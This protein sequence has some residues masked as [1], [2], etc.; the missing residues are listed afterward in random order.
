MRNKNAGFSLVELLVAITI[1]AVVSGSIGYLLITSL[2]M[3]NK[4]TV[5]VALQQELQITLNQIMDYAMESET[6]VSDF[7]GVFPDYLA[8]GTFEDKTLHTQIIWK[9]GNRLFLRKTDIDDFVVIKTD[10]NDPQNKT[11]N[12]E[13]IL[14]YI[15]N[16]EGDSS[17]LYLLA[18]YVKKF[19]SDVIGISEK[20]DGEGN[21][22]EYLFENPI[23]I[24]ITL[25]FE[26]EA[27][28]A[29][30]RVSDKALLRNRVV[31]NIYVKNSVY[32]SGAEFVNSDDYNK[33]STALN[34]TT[35]T[36]NNEQKLGY[37]KIDG[38]EVH[39]VKGDLNI[40]EIIPNYTYDYVQYGIGG[41]NGELLNS[42]NTDYGSDS[43]KPIS[44]AEMEGYMI[45][46]AGSYWERLQDGNFS[47]R[48]VST[49]ISSGEMFLNSGASIPAYQFL[50]SKD[51][52]G[53]YEYVGES[54][55]GVYAI[56][57]YQGNLVPIQNLGQGNAKPNI[58]SFTTTSD[59]SEKYTPKMYSP[60]FELCE[61]DDGSGDY[62]YPEV[63]YSGRND[64]KEVYE[65]IKHNE[66]YTENRFIKYEYVGPGKGDV[67]LLFKKYDYNRPSN[68]SKNGGYG[69]EY[70][71]R[72]DIYQY[73]VSEGAEYYG[74]IDGYTTRTSTSET[75]NG[76]DFSSNV[77][78]VEMYS[79]A[80]SS[81]PVYSNDFGWKWV[82]AEEGSILYEDIVN[83]N[84]VTSCSVIENKLY[85]N[86]TSDDGK[87]IYLKDHPRGRIINNETFKLL[88]LQDVLEQY[89]DYNKLNIKNGIWDSANNTYDNVNYS[90]LKKWEQDNHRIKL[91]VRTPADLREDDIDSAD[92]IVIGWS[93]TEGGFNAAHLLYKN[94]RGSADSTDFG[95][96]NDITFSQTVKIYKKVINE[97]ASIACPTALS[98]LS[99]K[100]NLSKLYMM[101]YCVKNDSVTYEEAYNDT[102]G[103]Y[104][105]NKTQKQN[106]AGTTDY[107]TDDPSY[108]RDLENPSK[109]KIAVNGSGRNIFTDF[110]LSMEGKEMSKSLYDSDTET[111]FSKKTTELAY[112][113]E[114]KNSAHYGDMVVKSANTV[115]D[116]VDLNVAEQF[117]KEWGNKGSGNFD[118][119][120]KLLHIN[121]YIYGR[122]SSSATYNNVTKQYYS[123]SYSE[124]SDDYLYKNQM[125][126]NN[127]ATLMTYNSGGTT[128]LAVLQ[129]ATKNATKKSSGATTDIIGTMEFV[130]ACDIATGDAR[131]A[132]QGDTSTYKVED[133]PIGYSKRV[134]RLDGGIDKKVLYLS[135]A[136][137]QKARDEGLY[138]YCV[139]KTSKDLDKYNKV[140]TWYRKNEDIEKGLDILYRYDYDDDIYGNDAQFHNEN[141][142]ASPRCVRYASG[143]GPSEEYVYEFCF[144]YELY[145]FQHIFPINNPV[146]IKD[147]DVHQLNNCIIAKVAAGNG[148]MYEGSD[149]LYIV[150][151]DDFDLD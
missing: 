68:Y 135:E 79:R 63:S 90:A 54:N 7:D 116:G 51:R 80:Y 84:K 71:V 27:T 19:D 35:T 15:P 142:T 82:E 109:T 65:K 16:N 107:W 66:Y 136:E 110:L 70:K 132:A 12:E 18:E 30:K 49:M 64:Y 32:S 151:R 115:I 91:S 103:N 43:I 34:I 77:V 37:L 104:K 149:E 94:I 62:Y 8:L 9:D 5:N 55:G 44:A 25:E 134:I 129:T 83:G 125:A 24:N 123:F 108:M 122:Y 6:V 100:T 45:K 89:T 52:V 111:M 146:K 38:D 92:L 41:K 56:N 17:D 148:L 21:H 133:H 150:I 23:S 10:P 59:D 88:M 139:V 4:E 144:K 85:E 140:V 69:V 78:R 105:L 14:D 102:Y 60:I 81:A 127:N 120:V 53:Y 74:Y 75:E 42:A 98:G 95:I 28:T 113:D 119:N 143:E 20:M 72:G 57:T 13:K 22:E 97:E 131:R 99:G 112:F 33:R 73:S 145:Y 2:R 48:N 26:K 138:L 67:S 46:A 36:V 11:I 121:D 101:L 3:Y 128:G 47:K 61:A 141:T 1:A 39:S 86:T 50:D 87:R 96:T 126:Y 114:D 40:L 93:G 29:E 58:L 31:N 147:T 117:I 130:G 118:C 124:V 76:Y 106:Q 137:Y